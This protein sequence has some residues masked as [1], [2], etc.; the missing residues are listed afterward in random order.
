MGVDWSVV[1]Q[2]LLVTSIPVVIRQFEKWLD[3]RRK[4]RSKRKQ[5]EEGSHHKESAV[6]DA[7]RGD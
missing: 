5:L 6:P 2:T 3:R 1:F 4:K 7:T